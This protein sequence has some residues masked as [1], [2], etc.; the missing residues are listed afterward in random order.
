MPP[1]GAAHHHD[2][3][4]L[5]EG[6]EHLHPGSMALSYEPA[7][8]SSMASSSPDR[9]PMAIMWVTSGGNRPERLSGLGDALAFLDATSWPR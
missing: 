6:G 4:G 3:H 7:M 2:H 1:D 9:S 8:A 5:E